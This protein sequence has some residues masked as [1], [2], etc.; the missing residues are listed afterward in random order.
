MQISVKSDVDQVR[1]ALRRAHDEVVD[2]AAVAA[3][4]R[5]GSMVR[6]EAVRQVKGQRALPIREIR[7][8]IHQAKAYG[9]HLV[10]AVRAHGRPI[11]LRLYGAHNTAHGVTVKV[12]PA[13]G[14]KLVHRHGNKA[15]IFSR[16]RRAPRGAATG[17]VMAR[18]GRSRLP[19]EKLYGP[20]IPT[21]FVKAVVMAAFKALAEKKWPERFKHELRYRLEKI[22]F[23]VSG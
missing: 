6:S 8:R 11:S 15:F 22:G 19:I 23:E 7:S 4:N 14:R 9:R 1:I 3:L 20:S 12:M 18:T 13:H 21:A 17:P 5:V 2:K 16:G 10:T